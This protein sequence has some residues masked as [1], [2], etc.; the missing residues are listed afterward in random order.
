[1]PGTLLDSKLFFSTST[2]LFVPPPSLA[3]K[4]LKDPNQRSVSC[5]LTVE[6]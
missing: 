5:F 1:M 6:I 3:V 4:S 2:V